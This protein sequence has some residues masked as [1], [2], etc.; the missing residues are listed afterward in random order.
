MPVF[1]L[2][3]AADADFLLAGRRLSARAAGLSFVTANLHPLETPG[4]KSME[5]RMV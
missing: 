5:W 3:A 4:A 1:L 2:P